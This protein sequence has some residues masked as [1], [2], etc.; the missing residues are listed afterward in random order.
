MYASELAKKVGVNVSVIRYYTR[1]GLLS[2]IRDPDNNYRLYENRDVGRVG[3]IRKAKWL[4]FTL[5]DVQSILDRFDAGRSPCPKVRETILKRIKEN[6]ER[7]RYLHMIQD[8]MEAA[9]SEWNSQ[10]DRPA[11]QHVC[12]L[13]DGIEFDEP[14]LDLQAGYRF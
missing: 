8:R 13:I 1:I 3:F 9:L 6:Q 5:K 14:E 2:P 12:G 11:G 4:G 7:L 10:E